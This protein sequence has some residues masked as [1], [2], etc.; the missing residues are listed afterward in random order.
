M[1][2]GSNWRAQLLVCPLHKS[3]PLHSL[4]SHPLWLNKL[5]WEGCVVVREHED[6][7]LDIRVSRINSGNQWGGICHSQIITFTSWM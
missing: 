4:G 1:F 6:I 5:F 3:C 2:G 7:P